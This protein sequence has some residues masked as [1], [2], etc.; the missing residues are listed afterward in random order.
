MS[1]NVLANDDKLTKRCDSCNKYKTSHQFY[2]WYSLFSDKYLGLI[3][4]SCSY[5]EAFG[6]KYKQNKK[7]KTW[8]E[9][10]NG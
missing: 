6:N 1:S 7:Y 5:K 8:K 2:R 9:K 3:C 10:N 4:T